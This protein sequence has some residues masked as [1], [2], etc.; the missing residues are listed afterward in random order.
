MYYKS[1]SFDY[2][3]TITNSITNSSHDG[4]VSQDAI[5]LLAAYIAALL[6][7]RCSQRAFKEFGRSLQAS[8]LIGVIGKTLS[9]FERKKIKV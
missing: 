7:R 1:F 4:K 8:D 9:E 6:T 2:A 5:P 3:H